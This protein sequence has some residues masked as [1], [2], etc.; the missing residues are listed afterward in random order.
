VERALSRPF[1]RTVAGIALSNLEGRILDCNEPCARIF[2]FDSKRQMLAHSAW[3]FYFD[4]TER[5]APIDRLGSRGNCPAEE[6]CLRD[7]NGLPVR[8]LTTRT[9]AGIA[10]AESTIT[11]PLPSGVSLLG[12]AVAR[13]VA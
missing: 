5:E 11:Q 4:R 2:R 3:D 6:V 12:S 9:V 8:V 7:R 13:V 10:K 1:D